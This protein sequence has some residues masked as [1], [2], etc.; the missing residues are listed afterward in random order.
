M[1]DQSDL[2]F[3]NTLED[4]RLHFNF[5]FRRGFRIASIL[6]TNQDNENWQVTL[7]AN[8]CLIDIYGEQ[9]VINIALSIMQHHDSKL[10]DLEY[11]AQ[12][13]GNGREFSYK[14]DKFP[15]SE[16]QQFQKIARFLENHFTELLAQVEK[17]NLPVPPL[18]KKAVA[19][20]KPTITP[21]K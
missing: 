21:K 13:I 8:N 18:L 4:I 2:K 9:G 17:E 16:A 7:T 3:R 15:V 11:L 1:K 14:P 12:F 6:F 5:L 19:Q 20:K 10:F